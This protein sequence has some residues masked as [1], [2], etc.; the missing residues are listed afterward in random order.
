MQD[1]SGA[2]GESFSTLTTYVWLLCGVSPL[3]LLEERP[4]VE[5]LAT[6]E[7]LIQLF[8][9]MDDVVSKKTSLIVEGLNTFT[10]HKGF[11]SSVAPVMQDQSGV[12]LLHTGCTHRVFWCGSAGAWG[13]VTGS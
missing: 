7:T 3:V 5:G 8:S 2:M 9:S 1:K 10:A 13:G 4:V 6:L 11:F 12:M